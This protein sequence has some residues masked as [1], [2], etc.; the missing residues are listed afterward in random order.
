MYNNA[1]D[2][3]R[4]KRYEAA[5]SLATD[6]DTQEDD[7]TFENPHYGLS[8]QGSKK[9]QRLPASENVYDEVSSGGKT[10]FQNRAAQVNVMTSAMGDRGGPGEGDAGYSIIRRQDCGSSESLI[11]DAQRSEGKSEYIESG[12]S[13]ITKE[14]MNEHVSEASS[15]GEDEGIE[16]AE[17]GEDRDVNKGVGSRTVQESGE[18]DKVGKAMN[19]P[20]LQTPPV[21]N[22][23]Q[24][25]TPPIDDRPCLPTPPP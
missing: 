13:V 23:P 21:D 2:G 7:M 9:Y 12:Y 25:Q 15:G 5:N 18:D 20:R 16:V 4:N 1:G 14:D 17:A 6:E 3:A 8:L 11:E 19:R 24:L 22:K 10:R